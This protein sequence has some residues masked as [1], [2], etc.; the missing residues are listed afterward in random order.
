MI[1]D[2]FMKDIGRRINP[3]IKVSAQNDN[4]LM[5]QELEEYVV[6]QEIDCHLERIFRDFVK[7]IHD[8]TDSAGVWIS[9]DFGSGKSHFLKILSYLMLNREYEGRR[10]V[11]YLKMKVS[12]STLPFILEANKK[13]IQPILF[14]IDSENRGDITMVDI[15]LLV[16]NRMLGYSSV[17][18]VADME[19]RLDKEGKYELFKQKFKEVSGKDWSEACS[20]PGFNKKNIYQT[21]LACGYDSS[22][23]EFNSKK[24]I[25]PFSISARDLSLLLKEYCDKQGPDFVLVFLVDEVGQFVT[26]KD[27]RLLN[28]QTITQEICVNCSGK[29]WNI[30]TAQEDLDKVFSN[31]SND[32]LS[33]ITGRFSTRVKMSASDVQEV[34]EKRILLKKPD[35]TDELMAYYESH[36]DSIKNKLGF[37]NSQPIPLYSSKKEFAATYPFVTYQYGMLQ[38]MLTDLRNK[39]RAGKNISNAA[40]SMLKT[41]GETLNEFKDDDFT[42]V[43]PMYSFYTSLESELDSPTLQLFSDVYRNTNLERFD[44]DVLKTL[45]L[46]KYYDQGFST[47]IDNITSMMIS[48]FDQN[49]KDVQDKVSESLSRLVENTLVQRVGEVYYFL[50]DEEQEINREIKRQSVQPGRQLSEISR[51]AFGEIFGMSGVYKYGGNHSYKFNREVDQ[52]NLDGTSYELTF[53][54]ITSM[55]P[56]ID[57]ISL[58]MSSSKSV[59]FKLTGDEKLIE[60]CN[61]YLQTEKYIKDNLVP[62]ISKSKRELLLDKEKE[63]D[64]MKQRF[65]TLLSDALQS[66]T[67]Y[68][69]ENQVDI[70]QNSPKQRADEA[71]KQLVQ[72]I[73]SKM[74]YIHSPKEQKDIE[75]IFKNRVLISF[76]DAC[77]S[78]KQ[79]I[80]DVLN[81]LESK[82]ILHSL[83]RVCDLMDKYQG[84][85]FGF[86]D[87]DIEWI[88]S[89]LFRHGKI[90]L[91]KD[92]QEYF[93]TDIQPSI[94]I[95]MI[96]KTK[97]HQATEVRLRESIS[98][99]SII[100]AQ[101]IFSKIT[102]KTFQLDEASLVSGINASSKEIALEIEGYIS[103][104]RVQPL[105]PGIDELIEIKSILDIT[106]TKKS[107][108]LFKYI[109]SNE[110]KLRELR[111]KIDNYRDFF[112]DANSKRKVLF[113]KG[114]E[115]IVTYDRDK[116]FLSGNIGKTNESIKSIIE[117]GNLSEL[118]KLNDL[119][120]SFDKEYS[121]QLKVAI[122]AGIDNLQSSYESLRSLV[123]DDESLSSELDSEFSSTK[124]AISTSNSISGSASKVS[125]FE[126]KAKLIISRKRKT[127]P[128]GGSGG[129][130]PVQKPSVTVKNLIPPS[131]INSEEDIDS[132]VQSVR[133]KLKDKLKDGPFEI[134][135]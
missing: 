114:L 70:A 85:P 90:S 37:K 93:G 133:N 71:M 122:A 65:R 18:P 111:P 39:S 126:Y 129:S 110:S 19:R 135:W 100:R 131:S 103:K 10:P 41:F 23:A 55:H 104:I 16:F 109:D 68:V 49:R 30:V 73:Y 134:N 102:S 56:K 31:F 107:P 26:N 4:N 116:D 42:I 97:N 33:K 101:T 75:N 40:R 44:I 124:Q 7:G 76:D 79:A 14:D 59:I 46:V 28:L 47:N 74:S 118:Y 53:G 58:A 106:S 15:Y 2:M 86:G 96:T 64:T 120:S 80:D 98:Q 1:K 112:D 83:V 108:E 105:Y 95:E 57:P 62:D 94:A 27:D 8:G 21:L 78:E 123:E 87:K 119:C 13:R 52:E 34:I 130:T 128:E 51:M 61:E 48:S 82:K 17:L 121:D 77:G 66:A 91:Y 25:T 72:K 84:A 3:V 45:F 117:S 127:E 38:K 54:I 35:V 88:I 32:Q 36:S 63:L 9:G 81:H 29:V 125:G 43:V 5:K 89:L 69:D 24:C 20:N 115:R 92:S 22:E 12:E 6:T 60:Q 132:L 99:D 50:T 113:D 67:I 11:D